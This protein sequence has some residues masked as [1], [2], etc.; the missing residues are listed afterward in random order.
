MY[1]HL[2]KFV[3]YFCTKT[4]LVVSEIR[5]KN[6]KKFSIHF[7]KVAKITIFFFLFDF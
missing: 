3:L 4:T 1:V 7:P 5:E 6:V 2:V